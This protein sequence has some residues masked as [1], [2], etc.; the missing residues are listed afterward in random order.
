MKTI[1]D[2]TFTS[3]YVLPDEKTAYINCTFINLPMAFALNQTK[4]SFSYC[5]F[6]SEKYGDIYKIGELK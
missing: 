3:G 2:R 5:S 1:R 6:R 4:Y